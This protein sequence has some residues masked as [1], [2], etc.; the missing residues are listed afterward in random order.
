MKYPMKEAQ[1][2]VR[3]LR[4]RNQPLDNI[5]KTY[6]PLKN[7]AAFLDKSVSYVYRICKDLR[8]AKQEPPP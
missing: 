7:I 8:K 1:L 2:M 5:T 6:M 3:L 4:Y